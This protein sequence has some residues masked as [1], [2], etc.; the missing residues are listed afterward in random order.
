MQRPRNSNSKQRIW[1]IAMTKQEEK[2]IGQ[3]EDDLAKAK[4]LD[5]EIKSI[6]RAIND[7]E[8]LK[9]DFDEIFARK[10]KEIVLKWAELAAE[11]GRLYGPH[12]L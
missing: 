5:A 11:R 7:M 1:G 9:E 6:V 2:D 3:M 10:K 4:M 8:A 12:N